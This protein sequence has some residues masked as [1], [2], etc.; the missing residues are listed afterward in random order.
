M[1]K[2][3]SAAWNSQH[4]KGMLTMKS[5]LKGKALYGGSPYSCCN[6]GIFRI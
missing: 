6:S 3:M 4:K 5:I 2:L 1:S